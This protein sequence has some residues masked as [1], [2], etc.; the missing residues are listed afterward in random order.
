MGKP[1]IKDQMSN[2]VD[3]TQQKSDLQ[4]VCA[5]GF[6]LCGKTISRI[7]KPTEISHYLLTF[8]FKSAKIIKPLVKGLESD[9]LPSA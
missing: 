1:C 9:G 7:R 5:V 8:H 3:T 4:L 2:F 6:I